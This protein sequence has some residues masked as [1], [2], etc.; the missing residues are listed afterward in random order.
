MTAINPFVLEKREYQRDLNFFSHYVEDVS[1]YLS[2][3][4]GDPAVQTR[5]FVLDNLRKGG[6]FEFKD[7][8]IRYYERGDNGDRTEK[9]GT[10]MGYISDAI[11]NGELI[12]PTFTTYLPVSKKKS[13]LVDFV[14]ENVRIRSKAKKEMFAAKMAGDTNM[15]NFKNSEQSN[16]KISNNS[17]SGA[18]VSGSSPLNNK[19][20]HSTLTSNCRCT[21]GYG[22]A[23]NEKMLSGNRHY[24]HPSI[25]INNIIS[26]IN[27]TDLEKLERVMTE[28]GMYY[29][30]AEDAA[31]V[32]FTSSRIYWKHRKNEQ[33]IKDLLT[34][35]KP[36]ER[37]AFVY[38]GDLFQISR[39][40]DELV[41]GFIDQLSSAHYAKDLE[42][43]LKILKTNREE[44]ILLGTQLIPDVMK[45]Q[46]WK[47]LD[48]KIPED[49]EKLSMLAST[50]LNIRDTLEKYR[51][52]IDCFFVTKNVPASLAFFP[53]SIRKSA[54]TS[55]TD[56]TIFTVQDWVK[57][58]TG[59]MVVDTETNRVAATMI[60]LAAEAI[61]H[62]LAR[63]SAN[64]GIETER[65]HQ[66]AMKNEFKFDVFVPTQVGKHY[67]AYIGCQEGNLFIEYDMEIKGVHL[68]SSN[69][70]A[71]VMKQAKN[72][73]KFIMDSAAEGKS[74]SVKYVL[75]LVAK[76]E[77]EIL[78]NALAGDS[79]FYRTL[80]IKSANSYKAK[81]ESSP[82]RH[83]VF[84]NEVFGAKYGMV[85]EPPYAVY[86]VPVRIP[87][88]KAMEAWIAS[89]EDAQ[90]RESLRRHVEEKG[91]KAVNTLYLPQ[92]RIQAVG[93]PKE[94]VSVID[95]RRTVLD[96]TA[97]FYLIL[98]TLGFYCLDKKINT[99]ASDF[100]AEELEPGDESAKDASEY[101][102]ARSS[103]EYSS[104]DEEE[105]EEDF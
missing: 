90:V 4:T 25:V 98:E 104:I 68:K 74:I 102:L 79:R 27:R 35:L 47:K 96:S 3:M 28:Y 30:T 54:L 60:F 86:K 89:I 99:L 67:F 95:L 94:I 53:T 84:W 39:Y 51:T 29:P 66:V 33:I 85:N 81:K 78:M 48:E 59:R 34:R 8:S 63:M 15:E 70:V 1:T 26:I 41:R 2:K 83:H 40:N 42:D 32:A 16:A 103:D 76:I 18:H 91:L 31:K 5:K 19:T 105:A 49:K 64:F 87:N 61:T 46:D 7:P 17:I 9:E 52:F 21:S 37:A 58:K 14:D 57:W 69:V 23:N 65:I 22:N 10:L 77:T 72:L 71:E 82:Y 36:V 92:Q 100:H 73:M 56:S 12:A 44:F 20:A 75:E 80:Q 6:A 97:V 88:A 55:D 11:Q 24:H 50:A 62:I 13:I 101:L 93:I 45:G 38:I 43:P